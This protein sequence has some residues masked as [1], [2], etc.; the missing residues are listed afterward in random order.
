[1]CMFRR[2]VI[3]PG[4]D[5]TMKELKQILAILKEL[6]SDTQLELLNVVDQYRKKLED[7]HSSDIAYEPR[8]KA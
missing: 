5:N 1:M 2:G 8:L 6:D 7:E 3:K 4:K